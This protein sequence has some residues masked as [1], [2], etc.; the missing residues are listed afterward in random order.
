V[1]RPNVGKSTLL[2]ALLGHPLAIT[3][4]HPQTTRGAVHGVL[5][6]GPTQFVFVD[7]PGIHTPRTRLGRWMNEVARQ[8][9]RGADVVVLVTEA[10]RDAATEIRPHPI[11][12]AL[13]AELANVPVVLV[14]NKVDRIEEKSRLLPLLAAFA[15]GHPFAAIIPMSARQ[16]GRDTPGRLRSKDGGS[17]GG[18]ARLLAE[19][20][21]LLPEGPLLHPSDTLS[22]QPERFF[23]AEL[24]REQILR[25]TRQ[26]VPHGVA[27]VVE[28]FDESSGVPRI[29]AIIH[30]ARE[31][32]TKILVGAKGQ[33]LKSIG[34]AS[35]ARLE[36]VLGRRVHLHLLV[37]ATPNWMDD[38]LRLREFGYGPQDS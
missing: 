22:V 4:P 33:M 28:R 19:L 32:H 27:V 5:T 31:A 14:L 3:S 21:F 15:E 1:G 11:D 7:T 18:V 12:L 9:G 34:A 2:N 30:V 25:H 10:P 37:R 36:R 23:A 17:D 24:V 20:R 26:E 35:R 6:V 13:A 8:Q 29:E 38:E 16:E